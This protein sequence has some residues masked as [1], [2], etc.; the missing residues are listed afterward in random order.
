MFYDKLYY[1]K[2]LMLMNYLIQNGHKCVKVK[3]DS[4]S[5]VA[6]FFYFNYTEDIDELV[7][8]FKDQMIA[9][10]LHNIESGLWQAGD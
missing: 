10:R 5:D 6:V 8:K 3:R 9:E 7:T 1:T 2:N 4:S